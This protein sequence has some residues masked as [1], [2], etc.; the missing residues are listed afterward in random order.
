MLFFLIQIRK[1]HT[2]HMDMLHL[3]Q[4]LQQVLHQDLVV[5]TLDLWTF[6][7][8]S[9]IYLAVHLAVALE[10]SLHLEVAVER[11]RDQDR[12]KV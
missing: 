8:Y 9:Q 7:I 5:L 12:E 4:I 10:A 6:L 3:I 11:V 2:I 1:K